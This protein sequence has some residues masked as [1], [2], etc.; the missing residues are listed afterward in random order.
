MC[1]STV[2]FVVLHPVHP[3]CLIQSIW[4]RNGKVVR[5]YV[6][7]V[8]SCSCSSA[9]RLKSAQQ[10]RVEW[11]NVEKHDKVRFLISRVDFVTMKWTLDAFQLV[12]IMEADKLPQFASSPRIQV[13]IWIRTTGIALGHCRVLDE[14][15]DDAL[16]YIFRRSHSLRASDILHTWRYS[17]SEEPLLGRRGHFIL[18]STLP[19]PMAI[20]RFHCRS[21]AVMLKTTSLL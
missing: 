6:E 1:N 12:L 16:L 13:C 3:R 4:W 20:D 8:G 19:I 10:T 18:V 17:T 21:L 15:R 14:T 11:F 5:A 2:W 9:N 7:W